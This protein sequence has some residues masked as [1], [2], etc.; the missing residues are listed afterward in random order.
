MQEH[1]PLVMIL[2]IVLLAV[3]STAMAQKVHKDITGPFTNPTEVT[4]KCIE[5]HKEAADDIMSTQ[6]WN[7][8]QK[9]NV[10]GKEQLYGKKQAMTNFA[11]PVEGNWPRCTVCHIGYGWEDASFDF[12]NKSRIDCLVCH[13]T[14][15]TYQK[16]KVGAGWPKGFAKEKLKRGKPVDL[17]EVA[18]NVG[19][20]NKKTCG[21]CHFGGCGTAKVKH[22]DLDQSFA[23]PSLEIDIHMSAEGQDFDCQK[24]HYPQEK[25]NI[26]G[27]YMAPSPDGTYQSGCVE[28]HNEAPHKMKILNTHYEAVSCQTCHIPTFAR[29]YAT[30][31]HWDWCTDQCFIVEWSSDK[32]G[33]SKPVKGLGAFTWNKNMVPT[34]EWY[35]GKEVAYMRGDLINND[36]ATAL[37][38]PEGNFKDKHSK[39][40]PFRVHSAKQI[41]D[42]K[43][44]Y[45]ITPYLTGEGEKAFWKTYDWNEASK[46]GM[47]A[48]GLAFSGEY[49]FATT[50]MYW[51]INH[52]VVSADK[53]LDC[54][55]C[56]GSNGRMDWEY[57]GYNDDPWQVK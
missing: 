53:S 54:L 21:T 22:G 28:C 35:N 51:R 52:G 23:G 16:A 46:K 41:Y 19:N 50:V 31:T 6:H 13:D 7:W 3:G 38:H 14:T 11:I 40:F 45:L 10:N 24:C 39:I 5:C 47:A 20:P 49:D 27:H 4:K 25:H 29:K 33:T 43:Y 8:E 2:V 56:H 36:G 30:K 37:N 12:K 57:L 34:Y 9:Q 17:L 44:N 18:Q 26:V 1:K 32:Y 15:G 42:T 55:D 48:S